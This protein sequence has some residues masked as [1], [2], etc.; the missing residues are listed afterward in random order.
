[1]ANVDESLAE[2]ERAL[3]GLALDGVNVLTNVAGVYLGDPSLEPARFLF[4]HH[5]SPA[6]ACCWEPTIL[7][8]LLHSFDD[9]T[10]TS[11]AAPLAL[12]PR[13]DRRR[14]AELGHRRQQPDHT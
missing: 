11:R 13:A 10:T 9:C 8:R 3:D 12:H 7:P 1:M 14:R 2:I 5:E 4:S 6:S